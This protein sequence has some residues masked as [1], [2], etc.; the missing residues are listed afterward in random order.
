MRHENPHPAAA[1]EL[2]VPVSSR[3]SSGVA[4]RGEGRCVVAK[5]LDQFLETTYSRSSRNYIDSSLFERI[6]RAPEEQHREAGVPG[7]VPA[8]GP[9]AVLVLRAHQCFHG[10]RIPHLTAETL[11]AAKNARSL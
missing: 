3:R 7:R 1:N 4:G 9:R 5:F 10:V 11:G 6:A 2:C 8:R